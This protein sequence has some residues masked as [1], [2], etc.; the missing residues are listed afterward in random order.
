[1]FSLGFTEVVE[2]DAG[3]HD[4]A[5]DMSEEVKRSPEKTCNKESKG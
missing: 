4:G 1:M 5:T 3:A 2:R